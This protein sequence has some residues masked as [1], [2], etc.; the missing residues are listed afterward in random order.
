MIAHRDEN[1]SFCDRIVRLQNGRI[2]E[3]ALAV[4]NLA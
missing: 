1:L 3:P 4:R 2:V